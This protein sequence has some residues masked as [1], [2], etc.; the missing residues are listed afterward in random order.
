MKS[1]E[2]KRNGGLARAC[3]RVNNNN[4]THERE[5]KRVK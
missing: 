4:V 3:D 5:K 1:T 2:E